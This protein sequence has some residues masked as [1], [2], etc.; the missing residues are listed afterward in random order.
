MGLP[1]VS[2]QTSALLLVMLTMSFFTAAAIHCVV[3]QAASQA[4]A[5]GAA[6]LVATHPYLSSYFLFHMATLGLALT[7]AVLFLA[8]WALSSTTL[9]FLLCTTLLVIWCN[10]TQLVLVLFAIA[11]MAWA[12]A[13]CCHALEKDCGYRVALQPALLVVGILM[14]SGLLY[15]AISA[16]VVRSPGST[17]QSTTR[18]TSPMN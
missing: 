4:L 1:L 10:S 11:G 7:Y 12:L 8:V 13:Q 17:R 16:A 5:L 18:H 15:F 9:K 3:S 6:A 14:S 2:S